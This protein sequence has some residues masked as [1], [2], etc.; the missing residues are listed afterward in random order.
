M[1]DQFEKLEMTQ[2]FCVLMGIPPFYYEIGK[3]R[4]FRNF[5]LSSDNC[6]IEEIPKAD[7]MVV[8][9]E[10]KREANLFG[11]WWNDVSCESADLQKCIEANIDLRGRNDDPWKKIEKAFIDFFKDTSIINGYHVLLNEREDEI[12]LIPANYHRSMNC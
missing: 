12:W 11:R 6:E 4:V 7:Y 1:L 8:E 10:D 9:S 2:Q 5:S 3:T